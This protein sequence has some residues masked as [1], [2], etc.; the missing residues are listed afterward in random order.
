MSPCAVRAHRPS[1]HPGDIGP[2][3]AVAARPSAI[4]FQK[5]ES[6]LIRSCSQQLG[7]TRRAKA[8]SSRPLHGAWFFGMIHRR[9]D[10]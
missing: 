4:F 3:T 7:G 5:T 1:L 6:D 2:G 10:G 8:V 9:V